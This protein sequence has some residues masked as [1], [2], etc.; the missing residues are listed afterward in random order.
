[1]TRCIEIRMKAQSVYSIIG[2]PQDWEPIE[3]A[4]DVVEHLQLLRDWGEFRSVYRVRTADGAVRHFIVG[5][6]SPSAS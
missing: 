2:L 5:R 1:M 3:S 6:S 4:A